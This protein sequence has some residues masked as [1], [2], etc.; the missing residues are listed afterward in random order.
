MESDVI[1]FTFKQPIPIQ[2]EESGWE[3]L[4]VGN[5]QDG[6]LIVKSTK[7]PGITYGDYL[8]FYHE[9]DVRS[10]DEKIVNR[11]ICRGVQPVKRITIT[12]YH[13]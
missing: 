6:F 10:Q 1:T 2:G 5:D 12:V 13:F 4:S 3:F 7:I 8:L 11:Y 9:K